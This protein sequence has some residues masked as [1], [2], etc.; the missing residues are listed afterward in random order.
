MHCNART[1][2][3]IAAILSG[4]LAVAYLALPDARE[5]VAAS[6]PVLLALICPISMVIMM[7]MM[8]KSSGA[9]SSASAK[10]PQTSLAEQPV[11]KPQPA[12]AKEA[13]RP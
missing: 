5:L 8:R 7:L 4:I 11:P 3:K 1:M 10:R 6:A 13:A 9:E 12:Q 2:L